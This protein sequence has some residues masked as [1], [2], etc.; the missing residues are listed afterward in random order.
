[1]PPLLEAKLHSETV[2]ELNREQEARE[3]RAALREAQQLEAG[4]LEAAEAPLNDHDMHDFN[5]AMDGFDVSMDGHEHAED[6]PP[7]DDPVRPTTGTFPNEWHRVTLVVSEWAT[8]LGG[9]DMAQAATSQGN[10]TRVDGASGHGSGSREPQIARFQLP[11]DNDDGEPIPSHEDNWDTLGGDLVRA[12]LANNGI[13]GFRCGHLGCNALATR[14]CTGCA[15]AVIRSR[16]CEEHGTQHVEREYC[17]FLLD[18][19]GELI[20]KASRPWDLV[21]DKQFKPRTKHVTLVTLFGMETVEILV[22]DNKNV[23]VVLAEHGFF[24][25]APKQPSN[26]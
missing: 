14:R 4:R 3:R 26:F 11:P 1:M 23:A 22:D 19:N 2:E 9:N 5:D 18:A 13:S 6:A 10:R 15:N 8:S 21:K 24:P 20:P 7:P 17:H 16:Y 12:Y 25:S